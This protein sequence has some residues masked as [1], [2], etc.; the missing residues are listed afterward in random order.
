ML[1]TT[2]FSSQTFSK[3]TRQDYPRLGRTNCMSATIQSVPQSKYWGT[4]A[5]KGHFFFT[6]DLQKR[7]CRRVSIPLSVLQKENY[8]Q[9]YMNIRVEENN[10][11]QMYLAFCLSKIVILLCIS[12]MCIDFNANKFY[13][14]CF[15]DSHAK[16]WLINGL[17]PNFRF[18]WIIT[19][20][21]A[22]VWVTQTYWMLASSWVE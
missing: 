22:D 6:I 12:Y 18:M 13:P 2:G 17:L 4:N 9:R 20:L 1:D 10:E 3:Q 19:I 5:Q 14:K 8:C 21:Y 15:R 7:Q 16:A 11:Q